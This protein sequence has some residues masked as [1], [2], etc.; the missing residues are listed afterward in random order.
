MIFPLWRSL[1][2]V[3]LMLAKEDRRALLLRLFNDE[4]PLVN[5]AQRKAQKPEKP[6]PEADEDEIKAD[7]KVEE[8]G[9][10]NSS[11]P[12]SE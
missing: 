4:S 6:G 1:T 2:S 11:S 10:R 9:R 5:L 3:N 7:D 12:V 8:G